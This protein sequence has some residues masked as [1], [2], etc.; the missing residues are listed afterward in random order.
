MP[1]KPVGEIIYS[2]KYLSMYANKGWEY[3][4]RPNC[5]GIVAILAVTSGDKILFVEQFRKPMN[6]FCIELPA[7]LAGDI[8]GEEKE[9]YAEAARREL[10]EETGYSC[11][12]M[13]FICEGPTS[14]GLTTETI[15]FFRAKKLKKVSAGGGDPHEKITVHEVPV[16]TVRSWLKKQ[17]S[18]GKYVD[19]K[20]YTGLYFLS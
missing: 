1:V 7:G 19:L 5:T 13:E 16:R 6:S 15:S 17:E 10:E 8:K 11:G 12:T 4:H 14:A 20:V 18:S 9:D 2:G 3:V